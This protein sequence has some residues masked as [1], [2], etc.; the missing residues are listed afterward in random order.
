VQSGI[1][2][3]IRKQSDGLFSRRG[4]DPTAVFTCTKRRDASSALIKSPL[5]ST[6]KSL[7]N[8]VFSRLFAMCGTFTFALRNRFDPYLTHYFNA[9][10]VG[11]HFYYY[12]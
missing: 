5:I 2:S 6:I 7:E 3:R 10:V 8:L 4:V 1:E 12:K 9:K 11:Q